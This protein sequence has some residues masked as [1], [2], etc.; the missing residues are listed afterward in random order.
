MPKTH[1]GQ[2]RIR[3]GITAADSAGA[4]EMKVNSTQEKFEYPNTCIKDFPNWSVLLR[5][6][7][8]TIGS[9]II[10]SRSEHTKFSDLDQAAFTELEQVVKA[11]EA[12]LKSLFAYA[13]IN[14][15]MLMMVDPHV[16]FHVFPRYDS[17]RDFA[18]RS[19]SDASWPK[20]PNLSHSIDL[21]FEEREHLRFAL[22]QEFQ[23]REKDI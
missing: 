10:I 23:R 12:S 1:S 3:N 2:R 14:Y 19:F 21:T 13:K 15:L 20:A 16:H 9:L 11:T 4:F 18:R 7:Q 6:Q 17:S 22:S 8:V 5:Q